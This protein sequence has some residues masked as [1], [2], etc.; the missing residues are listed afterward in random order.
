MFIAIILAHMDT[1]SQVPYCEAVCGHVAGPGNVEEHVAE[2][3][4]VK[5]HVV[6]DGVLPSAPGWDSVVLPVVDGGDGVVVP[7]VDGAVVV[8]LPPVSGGD[9]VLP[10]TSG[11]DDVILPPPAGGDGVVLPSTSGGD[12]VVLPPASGGD[13]V[14]LPPPPAGVGDV[15]VQLV[16]DGVPLGDGREVGEHP[17]SCNGPGVP[18]A[19][20]MSSGDTCAPGKSLEVILVP[21]MASTSSLE[22]KSRITMALRWISPEIA[23]DLRH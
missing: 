15:V 23:P 12:G 4:G 21:A 2:L 13:G 10:S 6:R 8:V 11:R 9:G 18:P 22:V 17:A 19:S 16:D 3:G 1:E 5:E 7:V 14:V 20:G